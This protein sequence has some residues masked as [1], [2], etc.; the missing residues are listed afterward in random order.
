MST[1][2]LIRQNCD[3]QNLVPGKIIDVFCPQKL[4]QHLP[5]PQKLANWLS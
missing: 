4:A 1:Y 3:I 5:T 2:Y